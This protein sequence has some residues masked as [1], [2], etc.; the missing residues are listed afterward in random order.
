M[1]NKNRLEQLRVIVREEYGEELDDK[2]LFLF[3]NGLVRYFDLITK[4]YHRLGENNN[5]ENTPNEN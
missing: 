3:A 4:L 2:Q 1:V 5:N